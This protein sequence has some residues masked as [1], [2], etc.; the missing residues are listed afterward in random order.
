[1]IKVLLILDNA[2]HLLN[3]EMLFFKAKLVLKLFGITVYENEG[4]NPVDENVKSKR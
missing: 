1:M 2:K 3:L 4:L